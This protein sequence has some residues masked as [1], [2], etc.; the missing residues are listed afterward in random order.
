MTRVRVAVDAMGGDRA[1]EEVVAGAIE[2]ASDEVEPVLYGRHELLEPL[3]GD[4]EIVHTE[5][6]V[7][8]DE[9][10]ADAAREKR[11]SS[12]FGA[13][14][15]V[16]EG[17]AGA[18]VSAGNT[19]AMLAAGLLEIRRLP[20]VHRPGIAVPLPSIG[21]TSVLIDAGANADARPEHLVQFAQM[22]A[23]FAQEVLA[24]REPAV[25][26]LSIG[27]E[28]EKGN[29]LVRETHP[30]LEEASGLHFIGNV[31][32]RDLLE[33][34]ADVVVCDGFT[35]NMTLKLMEGTIK[36]LLDALR[37]EITSSPGGKLGGLLIRPAARRLRHR[38]DPDTY[39]GAYLL[40]L[41]GLA[42][43]AHGSSSRTAIANAIRL[44]AQGARAQVVERVSLRLAER[45][46][47][48][49]T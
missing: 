3:A 35:G 6:V 32:S 43:I 34:V 5:D 49:R 45:V 31:E 48:I 4:L 9:K 16:G 26:L 42:V 11:E 12:M 24:V 20:D 1:P 40:G 33:H 36:T 17:S 47:A 2:A 28:A 21:G 29:R 41:R 10:P 38:L 44:G 14:R 8:M 15:A 27:E 46:G 30:L 23:V 19:G 7:A 22:G 39:G 25:A 18:V 37:A 13:C